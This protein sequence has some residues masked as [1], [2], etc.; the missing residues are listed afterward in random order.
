MESR[1]LIGFPAFRVTAGS[2]GS[3]L[4]FVHPLGERIVA[5]G[6]IVFLRNFFDQ[7]YG[8]AKGVI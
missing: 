2:S 5:G 3:L 4:L 8:K 7:I 6:Q 1:K